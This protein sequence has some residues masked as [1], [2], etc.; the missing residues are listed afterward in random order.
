[1]WLW[2]F[3]SLSL[4]LSAVCSTRATFSLPVYYSFCRFFLFGKQ[5]RLRR[6]PAGSRLRLF[7]G[8][9]TRLRGGGV[10]G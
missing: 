4:K 6:T 8:D 1:M 3:L 10:R 5:G 7:G 9:N 2:V